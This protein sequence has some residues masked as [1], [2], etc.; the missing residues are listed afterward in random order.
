VPF[1]REGH[2]GGARGQDGAGE[3]GAELRSGG[4]AQ[5]H[6]PDRDLPPRVHRGAHDRLA[7]SS[8]ALLPS[9]SASG[10][11]SGQQL[12]TPS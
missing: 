9:S 7:T 12:V 6:V 1:A 3:D 10:R 4:D 11:S 5:R 2:R 8:W